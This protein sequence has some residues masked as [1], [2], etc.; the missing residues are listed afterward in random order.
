M[1]QE[2]TY[3]KT[4]PGSEKDPRRSHR[5]SVSGLEYETP[6]EEV[7]FKRGPSMEPRIP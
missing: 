3:E 6:E 2:K 4:Y 1:G 7:L 5:S